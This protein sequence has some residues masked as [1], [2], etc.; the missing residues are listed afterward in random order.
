M[1]FIIWQFIK[2]YFSA[3]T[4]YKVHSPFV[5]DFIKNVL[6]DNR[7][8]YAYHEVETVRK[9]LLTNTTKIEVTDL[10][11]GS[12]F[13]KNNQRSIQQI[14]KTALSSPSFCR[15]LF[16]LTNHYKPDTIIEMGTSL[17][18]S[19]AY[20]RMGALNAKLL[21]LEGCPEISAQAQQVFKRLNL[22]NIEAKIGNFKTTLPEALQTIGSV[23]L[24]FFDGN[25]RKAPTLQYFN[26]AFEFANDN[27]VFIFDDIYWSKE[28]NEAWEI[29]KDDHR[30]TLSID[31]FSMGIL[32]FKK[33]FKV[34]QHYKLVK[35]WWKPWVMGFFSS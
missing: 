16:K 28:M 10:G 29:L 5:F 31:L 13:A 27:S 23:D 26:E 25:H 33:E 12:K 8:F 21:T 22:K 6:E 4:K 34:K 35:W 30:V 14:A 18:I 1:G 32:F 7:L 24:V 17:G 3:K 2:F 19:T 20:L 15:L 11:A 9:F